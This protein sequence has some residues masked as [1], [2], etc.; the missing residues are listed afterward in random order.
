MKTNYMIPGTSCAESLK[1]SSTSVS[2]NPRR[3]WESGRVIAHALPLSVE[4][5][6]LI[7]TPR[8]TTSPPSRYPHRE[9]SPA[10][11]W[12]TRACRP[13]P[14]RLHL[15]PDLLRMDS[16]RATPCHASARVPPPQSP[17]LACRSGRLWNYSGSVAVTG[18]FEGLAASFYGS[19]SMSDWHFNFSPQT[20]VSNAHPGPMNFSHHP[21]A[22]FS[23]VEAA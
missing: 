18:K 17:L 20:L 14:P 3:S 12:S 19:D 4:A 2:R 1:C 15:N 8:H 10:S 22:E 23:S 6:T 13:C 9:A 16:M 11:P 5:K 21:G 7:C